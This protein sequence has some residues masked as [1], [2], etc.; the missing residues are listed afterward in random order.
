MRPFLTPA[1]L[2]QWQRAGR[3]F[4][5][6]DA[7]SPRAF[8]AGHVPDA[9]SFDANGLNPVEGGVR[10]R[11]QTAALVRALSIRGLD[12]APVVIYGSR[13]GSDSALVWWT[14]RASGHPEPWILDGGIEAWQDAALPMTAAPPRGV[15]PTPAVDLH[16]DPAAEIGFAELARRTGDPALAV[17]DTRG[18]EEFSGEDQLA[19]RGGRIPGALLSPWDDL[20]AG[21][22]PGLAPESRLRQRLAR[23]L[24][25]PEAVTYCQSGARAAHTYAV[26]E[27]LGHP[28]PRLFMGS[29]AEWGNDPAAPIESG[30]EPRVRAQ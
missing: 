19:A 13:G 5:I 29:W 28:R 4:H 9:V 7:R 8:A 15:A 27:M 14:L 11:V 20:L 18:P 10:R 6:A 22:P 21:H 17:L 25:A 24:A 16:P 1:E 12:V 30:P 3:A 26:L 23:A 2:V